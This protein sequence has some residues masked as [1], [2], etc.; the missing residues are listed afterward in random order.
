MAM[1]DLAVNDGLGSRDNSWPGDG[2]II[3]LSADGSV[4]GSNSD[5]TPNGGTYNSDR[6]D[7]PRHLG[8]DGD[9]SIVTSAGVGDVDTY[10]FENIDDNF[11]NIPDNVSISRVT[12]VMPSAAPVSGL[13]IKGIAVDGVD[14]VEGDAINPLGG[15]TYCYMG[16]ALTEAPDGNS[17]TKAKVDS[18]EFGIK[19]G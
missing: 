13:G 11:T 10:V 9:T 8:N 16:S 3:G 19:T 2:H 12:V 7:D 18:A 4:D 6:V 17:W 1:D 14:S 15:L 5:W